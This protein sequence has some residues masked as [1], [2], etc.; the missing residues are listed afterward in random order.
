MA[1][2]FYRQRLAHAKWTWA[3]HK[4]CNFIAPPRRK[5][6]ASGRAEKRSARQREAAD[7][8]DEQLAALHPA[9]LRLIEADALNAGSE[10]APA[11]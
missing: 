5:D 6:R 2:D 10:P 11:S 7:I 1:T 3:E 4:A 9:E 8:V